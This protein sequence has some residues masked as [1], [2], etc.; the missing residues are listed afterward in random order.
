MRWNSAE[1]EWLAGLLEG[2][3]S[4]FKSDSASPV[5]SLAMCD[6]D[7]VERAA[8][9]L[10]ARVRRYGPREPG[11]KPIFQFT[12][13]GIAAAEAMLI[14][15]PLMSARREA[16]IDRALNGYSGEVRL[17]PAPVTCTVDGCRSAHKSR[18]FC[19]RHY[20]I[21]WEAHREGRSPPLAP[22]GPRR[23]DR[24]DFHAREG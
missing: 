19:R 23:F 11:Q 1:E 10:G 3:G 24:L 5:L 9:L 15:R 13:K 14:F 17:R 12:V 2:E 18:G 20:L 21:W 22:T 4:F 7:V 6:G 16:Q 8:A